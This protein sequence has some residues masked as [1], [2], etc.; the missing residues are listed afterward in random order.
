M[1][2]LRSMAM[3]AFHAAGGVRLVRFLNRDRLRIL[4][5]H[6]FSDFSG[7]RTAQ[8]REQC[9]HLR[10]SYNPVSLTQ[11]V[12]CMKTG[13]PFPPHSVVVTVDDG[14][15]DFFT[16]AYPVLRE[17]RI[18][19]ILY[20][21]SDFVDRRD[22]L[23]WD[24][25]EY[26][27]RRTTLPLIELQLSSGE[28]CRP[29]GS[30]QQRDCALAEILEACKRIP[31]AERLRVIS[32]VPRL[33][34]I[35]LP[36]QAP[37]HYEPLDWDQIRHMAANGIE[38]G[39]HTVTHPIL[40]RVDDEESLRREIRGCRQRLEQEL[41][42]PVVHFSYPNGD[43]DPRVAR[44]VEQAAFASAVTV[45]MG[46][47]HRGGDPLYLKRIELDSDVPKHYFQHRTAGFHLSR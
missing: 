10:R 24:K 3:S 21:V 18:P 32:D 12:S 38:F 14:Y 27:V 35:P 15:R 29:L 33:F 2:M 7:D 43:W 39:A 1:P 28:L 17:F 45:E 13:T 16:V 46:L 20:L 44:H 11:A 31:D 25:I 47:N 42:A 26:A 36:A 34:G 9:S 37:P 5:F 41:Q 22:W 8:W 40:P 6:R 30:A 23:W 4:G 19:A